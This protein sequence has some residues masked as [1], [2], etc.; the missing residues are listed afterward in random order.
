M[1]RV[2]AK[3]PSGCAVAAP[4]WVAVRA[5]R[6]TVPAWLVTV[7]AALERERVLGWCATGAEAEDGERSAAAAHAFAGPRDWAERCD[8]WLAGRALPAERDAWRAVLLAQPSTSG[9]PTLELD[10]ADRTTC[11]ASGAACDTS[12]APATWSVRFG[13]GDGYRT[14]LARGE[15]TLTITI[16]ERT[17]AGE[18]VIARTQ[19]KSPSSLRLAQNRAGWKA[20]RLL[21]RALRGRFAARHVADGESP[22]APTSRDV[23]A[24]SAGSRAASSTGRRS[25]W[26]VRTLSRA[27][28]RTLREDE[29]RLAWR[30]RTDDAL[31][32]PRVWRPE[33]E[34]APPRGHFFAD[35]FLGAH[36]GRECLFFEDYE[37]SSGLGRISAVELGS[38]G[39]P[40]PVFRVLE[41]PHHLSYPFVFEHAGCA[42]MIPETHESR[43]I[44]LWRADEFPTRWTFER[45]LVDGLKAVD[46]TWFERDGR[47]W[48]FACVAGEHTPQSEELHAFWSERPFGPWRP[49]AANPIVDD[50]CGAR[51]AGRPFVSGG[52]FVR[53]AQDV[54]GEYGSRIVF[55]ELVELTPTTYVERTLG[56]FDANGPLASLGTHHFDRSERFEVCD[57]RRSRFRTPRWLA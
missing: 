9:S 30:A 32:D 44:E 10:L 33:H 21:E 18:R 4:P 8:A 5:R 2:V 3:A 27:V 49:H 51:P 40:G 34:L 39:A 28:A 26:L 54:T 22:L 16:V 6:G 47:Y 25:P 45:V 52:R 43:R 24:S 14:E 7:L 29:W 1:T 57:A 56:S 20:A 36:A 46:A 19:T 31:P 23:P 12:R 42:Y 55:Q 17:E 41:R 48:L 53:P 13:A 35:P 37:T 11:E 50:P 15:P 38:D